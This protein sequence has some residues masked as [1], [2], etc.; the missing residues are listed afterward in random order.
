MQEIYERADWLAD[1]EELG[2]AKQHRAV[3]HAQIADRLRMIKQLEKAKS[4]DIARE[5][6]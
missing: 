2:E 5:R 1:M 4:N 6:K 3:I